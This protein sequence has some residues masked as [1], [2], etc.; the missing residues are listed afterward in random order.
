M[1]LGE[2]DELGHVRDADDF[3][4]HLSGEVDG[5]LDLSTV[6]EPEPLK[7]DERRRELVSCLKPT[8]AQL[9]PNTKTDQAYLA[10]TLV[11]KETQSLMNVNGVVPV[12]SSH[13]AGVVP[14]GH[15]H[16]HMSHLET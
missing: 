9:Q 12:M 8:V 7:Q 3:A 2:D 13:W 4:V 16:K 1:R 10:D 5:L 15:G 14:P 6:D 11:V